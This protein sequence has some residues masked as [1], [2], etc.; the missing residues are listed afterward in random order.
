[1]LRSHLLYES[2][3]KVTKS[4]YITSSLAGKKSLDVVSARWGPWHI[5]L[6]IADLPH[7]AQQ[8]L[9]STSDSENFSPSTIPQPQLSQ[10]WNVILRYSGICPFTSAKS[11]C[12]PSPVTFHSF[13]TLFVPFSQLHFPF[14]L[15]PPSLF[16]STS[17]SFFP[18][19]GTT[20][21]SLPRWLSIRSRHLHCYSSFVHTFVTILI[22]FI[23]RNIHSSTVF[24][25]DPFRQLLCEVLYVMCYSQFTPH[26][27]FP[28][29]STRPW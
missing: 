11:V 2:S 4:A 26:P 29:V 12:H 17:C 25:S 23:H 21:K 1:M 14:F 15:L 19:S 7:P 20:F 13:Q 28:A 5:S 27:F 9:E 22:P 16:L 18:P 24:S 3:S 6:V 8:R 10:L